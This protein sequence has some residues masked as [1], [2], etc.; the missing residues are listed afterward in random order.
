MPMLEKS[1]LATTNSISSFAQWPVMS[2]NTR[3]RLDKKFASMIEEQMDIRDKLKSI[4]QRLPV[5]KKHIEQANIYSKYKG[6]KH[7]AKPSK[8]A[9]VFIIFCGRNIV[10]SNCAKD[11]MWTDKNTSRQQCICYQEIQSYLAYLKLSD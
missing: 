5:L 3:V 9:R 6:K 11:R 4:E 1:P 10:N 8:S 7:F 2:V